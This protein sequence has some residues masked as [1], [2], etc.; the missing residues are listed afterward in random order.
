MF[1]QSV[2]NMSESFAL[3]LVIKNVIGN[4]NINKLDFSCSLVSSQDPWQ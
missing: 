4:E 2:L 1:C 3:Q